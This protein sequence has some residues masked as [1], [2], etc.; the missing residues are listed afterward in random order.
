MTTAL[1]ILRDAREILRDCPKSTIVDAM[2]NSCP[3]MGA[4]VSALTSVWM[5][6]PFAKSD[7]EFLRA[8]DTCTVSREH[9]L[10]IFEAAEKLLMAQ[11]PP[12]RIQPGTAVDTANPSGFQFPHTTRMRYNEDDK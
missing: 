9:L 12:C 10:Q 3:E 5:T 7:F 11:Q 6:P 1:Q 4:A 2:H 8:M